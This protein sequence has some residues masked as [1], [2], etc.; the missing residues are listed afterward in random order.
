MN[1]VTFEALDAYLFFPNSPE[2]PEGRDQYIL[3]IPLPNGPEITDDEAAGVI[4]YANFSIDN[5]LRDVISTFG[6]VGFK[7]QLTICGMD[8]TPTYGSINFRPD[9]PLPFIYNHKLVKGWEENLAYR[10]AL[11]CRGKYPTEL[12]R[13]AWL[14]EAR[15]QEID[16]Q[17][18]EENGGGG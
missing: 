13:A 15:E 16:R 3:E 7:G 6:N 18:L 1:R 2:R 5:L 9:E 10:R 11:K 12:T 14:Q 17:D 4:H 8:R